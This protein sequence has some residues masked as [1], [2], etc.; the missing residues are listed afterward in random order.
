MPKKI[1]KSRINR[2]SG[3]QGTGL[4]NKLIDRLPFE[5]HFPH[6][7]Y[8]G[9]GTKLQERLKR[10][11]PPL[12]PLDA[13][14]KEHDIAY[15]Q[16]KDTRARNQADLILAE[17]AW[18]RVLAKDSKLGEKIPAWLV[19]N[20]MKTKAKL[21]MG[22]KTDQQP[23][24]KDS[25]SQDNKKAAKEEIS[26]RDIIKRTKT[27]L[28]LKKPTNVDDAIELALSEAKRCVAGKRAKLPRTRVIRIPKTGGIL[29]ALLPIFAALTSIGS[30]ASGAASVAK[31]VNDAKNARQQLAESERHNKTMEAIAIGKGLYLKPY[32][33]GLGLFL[34]PK[35]F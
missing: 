5:A 21:G 9:P 25:K 19:A 4:L 2:R 22:M 13:A 15:S 18:Q 12:N 11:D 31:A 8:C 35:N 17:K 1:S 23:K 24:V 28:K 32:K 20:A 14:C 3:T 30:I 7:S 29:P 26:L 16:T 34:R 33:K 27:A 6:Y 10:G